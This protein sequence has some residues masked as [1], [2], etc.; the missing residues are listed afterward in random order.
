MR[1][2][3]PAW[4]MALVAVGLIGGMIGGLAVVGHGL[5]QQSLGLVQ[6]PTAGI[7]PAKVLQAGRPVRLLLL[8]TSLTTESLRA[9]LEQQFS[10]CRTSGVVVERLAKPGANSAWGEAALRARLATGPAPD[11]MVVEFSINDSSLWRGMTLTASRARHEELLRMAGQAGVT[12]WLATM[13][14]AF[15]RK[16]WERPGQVAYRAL[17][18]DLARSHGA[19]LIAMVPAWQAL[20]GPERKHLMPDGLHPT[21]AAMAGLARPALVAALAKQVCDLG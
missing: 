13:S 18:A 7:S 1:G 5:G 15:G 17:Y 3:I 12:V 14:P 11:V 16:A 2:L 6:E 21:E 9:Q 10:G 20:P 4:G 19:G 8:G